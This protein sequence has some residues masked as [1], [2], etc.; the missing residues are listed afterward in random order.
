MLLL[1]IIQPVRKHL[2]KN[3]V[4]NFHNASASQLIKSA[5][6]GVAKSDC[7]IEHEHPLSLLVV[8]I[9]TNWH[10]NML[11]ERT[12]AFPSSFF[13]DFLKPCF[14]VSPFTFSKVYSADKK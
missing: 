14:H 8:R 4:S 9:C 3:L 12:S 10:S 1:G 2:N 11:S 6:K 5:V 13:S 7:R